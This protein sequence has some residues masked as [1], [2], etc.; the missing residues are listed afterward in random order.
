MGP[1]VRL[2][3]A[4]MRHYERLSGRTLSLERVMAWHVRTA[5]GDVVW[6]TDLGIP[7]AD[8]RTAPDWIDDLAERFRALGMERLG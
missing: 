2:L 7:L 5:L 6:R 8:H 3:T 4:T 1:G